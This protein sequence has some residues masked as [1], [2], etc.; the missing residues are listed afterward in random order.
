MGRSLEKIHLERGIPSKTSNSKIDS[1][2]MS[3]ALHSINLGK[4]L[5]EEL[6]EIADDY[7]NGVSTV[8]IAENYSLEK[9]YCISKRTAQS[10][11]RIALK[12]Y[13][14]DFHKFDIE[15]FD[16]LLSEEE[17]EH[18]SRKINSDT[19]FES[20]RRCVDEGVGFF[21]FDK[22]EKREFGR[23]GALASG[24]LPWLDEEKLFVLEK[25]TMP[26]DEYRR[27][28]LIRIQ[29][30]RDEINE[31]YH[32]GEQVRT[33]HSIKRFIGEFNKGKRDI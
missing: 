32:N 6:P 17:Y 29:K 26:G 13:S 2:N 16:G 1:K 11:V 25:V 10:A 22:N 24:R 28:S 15:N 31:E 27:G 12:G 14:S 5:Q 8:K 30:I 21:K 23:K 33:S 7:R 3:A 18:L 4:M 19:G 9:D 20:G